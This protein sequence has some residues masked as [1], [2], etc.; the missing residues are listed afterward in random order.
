MPKASWAASG[1]AGQ[2]RW[3]LPSAQPCWDLHGVLD[4]FLFPWQ[5]D[6]DIL[7]A[8]KWRT[9]KM[10]KGLEHLSYEKKLRQL[11]LL[12]LEKTTLEKVKKIEPSKWSID[13][14]RGHGHKLKYRKFHIK[15][16]NYIFILHNDQ[17]LALFAWKRLWTL[18][19]PGDIKILPGHSSEK[20]AA[21][22]PALSWGW[23]TTIPEVLT[24]ASL[25]FCEM[26][27]KEFNWLLTTS[28]LTQ[29]NF[30]RNTLQ[31]YLTLADNIS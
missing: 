5:R 28:L 13:G 6:V 31:A 3:P 25:W 4:L 21:D 22:D 30:P 15:I 29:L 12:R 11:G 18:S 2:W 16:R 9:M 17:T 8:V 10:R 14:T 20:P 7:E 27:M 1:R 19:I 26:A 24:S 23:I